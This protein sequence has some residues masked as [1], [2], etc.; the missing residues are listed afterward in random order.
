[1]EHINTIYRLTKTKTET[2]RICKTLGLASFLEI[3]IRMQGTTQML[4]KALFLL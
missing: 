2:L 3:E 4:K 1:M